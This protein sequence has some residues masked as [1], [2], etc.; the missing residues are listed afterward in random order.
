MKK[1]LTPIIAVILLFTIAAFSLSEKPDGISETNDNS[2]IS[3]DNIN[4][5]VKVIKDSPKGFTVN[6]YNMKT[7][8]VGY[9]VSPIKNAEIKVQH[10]KIDNKHLKQYLDDID[11]LQKLSDN[12]VYAAGWLNTGDNN[13]YLDAVYVLKDRNRALYIAQ[14]ANQVAIYD[15]QVGDE[16]NTKDAIQK[17]KAS[18][19]YNDATYTTVENNINLIAKKYSVYKRSDLLLSHTSE[20]HQEI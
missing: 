5:L 3:L 2:I 8:T 11:D 19:K 15:L 20:N 12:D 6:P 1:I 10:S 4:K 18:N 9:V 7:P 14:A 16:I 13:Y 17:L